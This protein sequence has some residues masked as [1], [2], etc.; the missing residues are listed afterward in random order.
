MI[1]F[2]CGVEMLGTD[3]SVRCPNC[4]RV[5]YGKDPDKIIEGTIVHV[6]SDELI[7]KE[8]LQA[9]A[10]TEKGKHRYISWEEALKSLIDKREHRK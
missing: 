8:K 10:D 2:Y 6:L 1:C 3:K 4:R 7:E 9:V 5:N